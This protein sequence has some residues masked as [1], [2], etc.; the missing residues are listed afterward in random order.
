MSLQLGKVLEYESFIHRESRLLWVETTWFD[1]KYLKLLDQRK[2]AK[3]QWLQ[4]PSQ[5]N[6]A[7]LNNVRCETS[8]TLTNKE[9]E[10]L[11]EKLSL[12]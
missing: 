11:E 1:E 8:K 5:T 4:N 6:G 7:N 3:L 2:Q 10:Y 12:K 9:K